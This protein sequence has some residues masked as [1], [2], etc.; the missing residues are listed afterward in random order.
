MKKIILKE[1]E[2]YEIQLLN[3][4]FYT[5][6]VTEIYDDMFILGDF[7]IY[8]YEVKSINGIFID[9]A[10]S[11]KEN[12]NNSERYQIKKTKLPVIIITLITLLNVGA[13]ILTDNIIN[14]IL[15]IIL[16]IIVVQHVREIK[17]GE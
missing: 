4:H 17:D 8:F 14:K 5:G 13:C 1:N 12:V 11:P 9:D 3:E 7:T 2:Y 10:I 15:A 16:I 6:I